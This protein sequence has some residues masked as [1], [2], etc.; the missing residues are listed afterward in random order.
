MST[1]PGYQPLVYNNRFLYCGLRD[2]SGVQRQRVVAVG[3]KAIRGDTDRKS[4]SQLKYRLSLC[5]GTI[6]SMC[7]M[8]HMA[9]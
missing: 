1:V 9:K 7:S 8:D 6:A 4:I 5:S 3:M 2:Q